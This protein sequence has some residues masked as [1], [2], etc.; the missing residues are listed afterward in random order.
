M[1]KFNVEFELQDDVTYLDVGKTLIR[2]AVEVH[3]VGAQ[4]PVV[5]EWKPITDS[6]G[7]P[8]GNWKVTETHPCTHCHGVGKT[9]RVGFAN[10]IHMDSGSPPVVLTERCPVCR[11]AG[12]TG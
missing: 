10:A 9:E 7:A 4:T 12:Y 1:K 3:P 6:N 8:V 11:G 2:V 5:G